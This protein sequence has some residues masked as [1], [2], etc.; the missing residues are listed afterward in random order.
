MKARLQ[1]MAAKVLDANALELI[2]PDLAFQP[3]EASG[4]FFLIFNKGLAGLD[5]V[6]ELGV[7]IKTTG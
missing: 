6:K 7:E 4:K 5:F 2:K 1:V 3:I